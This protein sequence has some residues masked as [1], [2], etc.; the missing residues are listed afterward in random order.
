MLYLYKFLLKKYCVSE[1]YALERVIQWICKILGYKRVKEIT[2]SSNRN[3]FEGTKDAIKVAS[4]RYLVCCCEFNKKK[5]NLKI[6]INQL[7]SY[8]SIA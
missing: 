3:I 5:I 8:I 7:Q 2:K 6:I 4:G 1:F